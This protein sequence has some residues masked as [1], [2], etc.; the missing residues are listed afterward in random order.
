MNG[1]LGDAASANNVA[2]GGASKPWEHAWTTEEM[3]NT[4]SNWHLAN[5]VG[6]CY[7]LSFFTFMWWNKHGSL[8]I[9]RSCGII[10]P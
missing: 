8:L 7:Y 4:A 5:D 3:R 2:E 9:S 1:P 6:V 10:I